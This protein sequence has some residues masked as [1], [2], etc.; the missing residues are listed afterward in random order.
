[1]AEIEEEEL[2]FKR[3]A[4]NVTM[5]NLY[6]QSP[7][8]TNTQ[9]EITNVT[10]EKR[11]SSNILAETIKGFNG[12]AIQETINDSVYYNS[13]EGDAESNP[14]RNPKLAT[15]TSYRKKR[16]LTDTDTTNGDSSHKLLI[17]RLIP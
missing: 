14:N 5:D 7:A 6:H 13:E 3:N 9:G 11:I 10:N 2:N 8:T 16:K 17:N 12:L 15:H 1:M 4:N